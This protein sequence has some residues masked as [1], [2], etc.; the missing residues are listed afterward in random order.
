M[1]AE[2]SSPLRLAVFL[3]RDGTLMH[4]TGYVAKMS[5]VQLFEGVA[6]ALAALKA[7]GFLTVIVT[8]QSGIG[9]GKFTLADYE[10]VHARFLELLGPGLI[11]ATYMCPDHPDA[12]TDRRKPG[13]GMLLE[14]AR[15]L[16]IDLDRS[17][18]IGD[19]AGDLEAGRNAGVRPILVLTGE[20][21]GTDPSA[22]VHIAPDFPAA[23]NFILDPARL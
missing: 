1:L 21:R 14:A 16:A 23:V 13:P 3:D 5:D 18:M 22:A 17:W 2:M 19:R 6:E 15:D 11:D 9:R 10:A 8:N 20:G 7:R 4:D 12:A